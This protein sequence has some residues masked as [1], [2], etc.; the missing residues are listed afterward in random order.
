MASG[1]RRTSRLLRDRGLILMRPQSGTRS[2]P[3]PLGVNRIPA[4]LLAGGRTPYQNSTPMMWDVCLSCQYLAKSP[5]PLSMSSYSGFTPS[6]S[7]HTL[8]DALGEFERWREGAPMPQTSREGS[9][10]APTFSGPRRFLQGGFPRRTVLSF[11][12][13]F[14]PAPCGLRASGQS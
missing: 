2:T 13:L 10:D 5:S 6:S 8:L 3:S 12:S 14:A 4:A 11:G 9:S 1:G 7:Q